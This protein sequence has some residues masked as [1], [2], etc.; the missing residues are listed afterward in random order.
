MGAVDRAEHDGH[1]GPA[2]EDVDGGELVHLAHALELADVEAVQA[3]ELARTPR[4]Q[5][6]PEGLVLPA[7]SVTSPVVAAV[8]AAARARRW[9]RSP[10][11]WATRCFCTVDLAMENPWSPSR[12]AYWRQPM[13]GSVTARV[14]S[15]ST[16]WVGVASGIWGARRSLGIRASSP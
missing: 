3:D 10:S 2:G 15:A 16:T 14:N 1:E 8:M 7:A 13:V 6:E 11:P 4:G 5:A 9:A 12:S